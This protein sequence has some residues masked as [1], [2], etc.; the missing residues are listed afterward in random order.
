MEEPDMKKH[1][2]PRGVGLLGRASDSPF[3]RKKVN[4]RGLFDLWIHDGKVE[5][6]KTGRDEKGYYW[7]MTDAPNP[8][9]VDL[10]QAIYEFFDLKG[11][12]SKEADFIRKNILKLPRDYVCVAFNDFRMLSIEEGTQQCGFKTERPYKRRVASLNKYR[13]Y[14]DY[15][16]D[17]KEKIDEILKERLKEGSLKYKLFTKLLYQPFR[18]ADN[19][20]K[21]L[22]IKEA[23]V[24]KSM[25]RCRELLSKEQ[26]MQ[27]LLEKFYEIVHDRLKTKKRLG[28]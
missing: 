8:H 16:F 9:T 21:R 11:I 23:I 5:K 28:K 6:R 1:S 20:A 3:P 14:M 17:H 13:I 4:I 22:K 25:Q 26:V 12:F 15:Y 19:I 2:F 27:P 18:T 10:D 24:R 7:V